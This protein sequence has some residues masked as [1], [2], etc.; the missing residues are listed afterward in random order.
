MHAQPAPTRQNLHYLSA[1]IAS[2][3][4]MVRMDITDIRFP[5]DSFDV[6]YASHVL[7][8]VPDDQ[9][10]MREL[11]RVL[12]PG[13]WAVLQ[14]PI[15]R[16]TTEEDPTV[17]DPTERERRFG[18][19]DHVRVYG[20]DGE[21]ER[22][23]RDGRIRREGRALLPRTRARDAQRYRLV[24]SEDIYLCT[25]PG[26]PATRRRL[27]TVLRELE[28]RLRRRVRYSSDVRRDLPLMCAGT[29]ASARSRRPPRYCLTMHS[30]LERDGMSTAV[31]VAGMH[32]CG[33][34]FVAGALRFLGVSLG[35][36]ERLMPPGPDNPVGY[37]E[38]ESVMEFNEG[39]LA[40]LGGAWDQP[41][42]LDPG[43]EQ[44]SS[45]DPFRSRASVIL[46]E[47]FGPAAERGELIGFKDPRL[48]LLLP[49]WR[50][51]TPI[52]TTIVLVRDPAEVAASLAAR[53]Y[54]VEGPQAASLWLRYLFAATANDPDHLMLRY[55]DLFD[56][57]R[58]T[59]AAIA[60]HIGVAPPDTRAEDA[61][62]AHLEPS[63][64][65]HVAESSPAR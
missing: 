30:P 47:V 23:F 28:H 59:L 53:K 14:V 9:Q 21:Y 13:G 43:W 35:D 17:T 1:D 44:D 40:D 6:I 46:D 31:C 61:V 11:H 56:D 51:V 4:A 29:G 3:G 32:R 64:R 22:R 54:R 48:S 57:L 10:A 41:P 26:P 12:R 36:P 8:H 65:H 16:D 50:T 25:K 19:A 49:F 55:R 62:R 45:L 34:S 5:A 58:G 37:F 33:T 18:Q 7:E 60:R 39:L 42:V 52:A 2:P 24:K 27:A 63:L 38:I 20:R 15:V